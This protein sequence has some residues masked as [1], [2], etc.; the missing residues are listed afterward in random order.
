MSREDSVQG[1]QCP[2]ETM[3]GEDT[4]C[5]ALRSIVSRETNGRGGQLSGETVV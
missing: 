1:R 5:F 2:G 3:S 4:V